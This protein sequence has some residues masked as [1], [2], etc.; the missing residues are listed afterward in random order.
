MNKKY[1]I[2]QFDCPQE[3]QETD[4]QMWVK[5]I[6]TLPHRLK[7]LTESLSEAE[8]SKMYRENSWNVFQLIHHIVDSHLNG[9]MRMKLALTEENP[10]VKT[11]EESEWAKLKDYESPI[12]NSLQLLENLHKRW[13]YLIE[14]LTTTQLQRTY[15]YP[16]GEK[17]RLDQ[18]IALYAWHGNHHLAHIE[19]ALQ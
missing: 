10:I 2:G 19:Q 14:N 8:L 4:I 6:R 1:P 18:S 5:E 9:Y 12:K 7:R 15:Q 3:V 11:Y 17:M 13:A 16:D